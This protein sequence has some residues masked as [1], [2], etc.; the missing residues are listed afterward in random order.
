V[1]RFV[2]PGLFAVDAERAHDWTVAAMRHLGQWLGPHAPLQGRTVEIAGLQFA[3]P[4]GLAAGLDK[5][6]EAVSGLS[7]LGFGHIEVGTVTPQPQPGNDKPRVFRLTNDLGLINRFGFNND[8]V[9]ALVRRLQDH[10]FEGVIGVNIGKNKATPNATAAADYVACVR[11]VGPVCDYVTVNLSSPNTPGLRDLADATRIVE[12]VRPVL[13]ARD[14]NRRRQ[15]LPIFVKLAPDFLDHDLEHVLEALVELSIDGVIL[16]NTTLQRQ[17]L[18]SAA[19]HEQGGLSGRPLTAQSEHC[20]RVA[21]A[22]LSGRL[23]IISVGGIMTADDAQTRLAL[24]AQLVQIYT[25]L[26]YKGPGLVKQI[27]VGTR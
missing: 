25:G 27:V 6:A 9:N 8:G 7:R 2:K 11:A 22:H 16:T 19:Q 5:N 1:Y 26:I 14:L 13:D 4:V 3:N 18:Q 20:L 10:P 15:R 17:S 12:I 21:A 23:P 24:G